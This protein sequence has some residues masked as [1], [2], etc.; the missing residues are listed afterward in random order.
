MN[1]LWQEE[2][3]AAV[4]M[5]GLKMSKGSQVACMQESSLPLTM[6]LVHVL[7][8]FILKVDHSRE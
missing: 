4:L 7:G 6:T 5:N 2:F 3:G 8:L 1:D